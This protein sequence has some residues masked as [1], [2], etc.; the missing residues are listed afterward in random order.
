M[1]AIDWIIVFFV[2]LVALFGYLQGFVVGALSLVGFALGAFAGT[3]L[4]PLVLP[5]GSESPYAPLFGLVGALA[6]GAILAAGLEGLGSALRRRLRGPGVATAD[7]VLG[8][9]LTACVALGVA[10][11]AAAVALQTPAT[12][13]LRRDI[14]RSFVLRQLNAVLPPSGP[15]LNA[16][17][18]IDPLPEVR[19]PAPD[20][21]PPTSAIARDR[22]VQRAGRSVVRV[23]GTACGLGVSGSGWVAAPDTVVTNAH[24]VAGQEDT[25]VEV[26]GDPPR[27]AAELVHFDP[28]NDIAVL[29][30]DGL[31]LAALPIARD[32]RRGTAAAIL[33]YPENGPF[34]SRGGRLGA[35]QVALTQDAYGRGPLRRRIVAL[36]GVVR[37]GN[38]G[39]PM[40]DARGRVVTTV[41]AA[42]TGDG[43]RGGYGVPDELVRQAL[44]RARSS[45]RAALGAGPCT[46]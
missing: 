31:D 36:R 41:F 42:T 39:G 27:R 32:P 40:V 11:I 13:G 8:A 43:P 29:R 28:R 26:G 9:L 37:S 30:V 18:R 7:S 46:R 17:S 10:W 12:E 14:Q 25:A 20:V 6:V 4:G 34:D 15:L 3:R 22:D 44:G 35:E 1:T 24:V 38:S 19:G 23:V 33:G 2:V 21:A 45:G 5:E 16:L